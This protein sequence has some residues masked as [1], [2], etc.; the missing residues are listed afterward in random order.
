MLCIF[1]DD[2][3][4]IREIFDDTDPESLQSDLDQLYKWAEHNNMK[5]NGT[6]FLCMKYGK[7]DIRKEEYNYIN[8]SYTDA[9]AETDNMRDLGVTVSNTGDFN[10]HIYK[11]TRKAKQTCGWI[12]RSFHRNDIDFRRH[13]LRTY[14]Q[15]QIDYASQLWSPI[16][17]TLIE[18]LESAQKQYTARTAGLE[19]YNYWERLRLM[20]LNSIQRRHER[21]KTLY[22]WKTIQGLVPNYGL[23]WDTN[24]RRGRVVILPQIKSTFSSKAKELREQSLIMH[25][26]RIFIMLP[27]DFRN[28]TGS[29]DQFKVKLDQFLKDIP[30]QPASPGLIPEPVSSISCKNSN[31]LTDWIPHLKLQDRRPDVDADQLISADQDSINL[32]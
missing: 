11:I 29:K 17:P 28:W 26:G 5:Y 25:G 10:E 8:S 14:I 20:R 4:V 31:S 12:S 27:H 19:L 16:N 32:T 6:K 1:A 3:R 22:I 23:K 7:N 13:M 30:D 9:I 21:Y 2:I 18:H 24:I 15:C